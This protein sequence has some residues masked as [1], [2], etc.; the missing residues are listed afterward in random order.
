MSCDC[1]IVLWFFLK[2]LWVGLQCVIVVFLGHTH[3]FRYV[4]PWVSIVCEQLLKTTFPNLLGRIFPYFFILK[5]HLCVKIQKFF[6]SR[7]AHS[8]L[9]DYLM[10]LFRERAAKHLKFLFLT[11]VDSLFS[12]Y[13]C[14]SYYPAYLVYSFLFLTT[15]CD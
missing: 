12:F 11:P 2:V 10:Y 6:L 3:I 4:L 13:I 15:H 14:H 7:S 1:Y 5:C 9:I 8:D